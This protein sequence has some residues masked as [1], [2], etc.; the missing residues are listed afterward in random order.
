M[1]FWNTLDEDEREAMRK[2]GREPRLPFQPGDQILRQGDDRPDRT[3]LII[4]GRCR[5]LW[6]GGKGR[7]T[8]LGTR[9]DGDLIGE[10]AVLDGGT[11]NATVRALTETYV[12]W[13]AREAFDELL[14]GHPRIM[15]KLLTSVTGRL[16][17]ADQQQIA[18]ASA[19]PGLRVAH[20]LLRLA[21]AEGVG[22]DGGVE[23]RE[24]TRQD[25]GNWTGMGR[26]AATRCVTRLQD[27]GL[28]GDTSKNRRRIVILDLKGLR[29]LVSGPP[30]G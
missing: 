2:A 29:R 25:L 6:N 14:T 17:E 5:V 26:D 21:D 9:R 10:M 28:L 1:T 3:A 18:L 15:R 13:W 4:S 30:D 8:Y 27:L 20:L 19:S 24:L 11:R 23:I 7:T 16:K 12:R 22:R